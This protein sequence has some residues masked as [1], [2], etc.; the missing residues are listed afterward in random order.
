MFKYI[1]SKRVVVKNNAV[2]FSRNNIQFFSTLQK[3]NINNLVIDKIKS[4]KQ[5]MDH[6]VVGH[7]NV[8]TGIL[9]SN[10][11][12]LKVHLVVQKHY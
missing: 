8:K 5:S 4:L 2:L 9:R 1:L 11:Y 3:K 7:S 12:I 6:I 10:I